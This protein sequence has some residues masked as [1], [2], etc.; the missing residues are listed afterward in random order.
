MDWPERGSA[1]PHA[2]MLGWYRSLIALR[3]SEPRLS[4]PRLDLVSVSYDESARWL[5]VHRGP[6]RVVLNLS[7]GPQEV[8][9]D[10]AAGSVL[11]TSSDLDGT[12][13]VDLETDKPGINLPAESVAILRVDD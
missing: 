1:E 3:K 8:P 9:L 13:G 2:R 7:D 10:R 12:S 6:L 5:V 11:L 4:D